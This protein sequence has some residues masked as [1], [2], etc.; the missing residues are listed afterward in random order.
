MFGSK[1]LTE[2]LVRGAIGISATTVALMHADESFAYPV[3]LLP[4]AFLALRG[5]PMCWLMGL[6]ETMVL[7]LRGREAPDACVDGSCSTRR[8]YSKPHSRAIS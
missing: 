3:V 7:K 4:I 1:T 5:C 8:R 6:G 2:H